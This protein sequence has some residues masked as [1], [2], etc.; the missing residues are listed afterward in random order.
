METVRQ[1]RRH[2]H[3]AFYFN[4]LLKIE[5]AFQMPFVPTHENMA[6]LELHRD[7]APHHLAANLRRAFSGIVA[8]NVKAEGIRAIDERGPFEL[9]GDGLLLKRL[10]ELLTAFVSQ[11]RMRLPGQKYDPCYRLNGSASKVAEVRVLG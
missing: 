9:I 5:R 7:Q 10:D 4:W 11:G 8:G 3:D 2:H 1:F 6:K